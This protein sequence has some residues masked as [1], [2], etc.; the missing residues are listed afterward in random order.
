METAQKEKRTR[1]KRQLIKK[2]VQ[3]TY[4]PID[5][6]DFLRQSARNEGIRPTT[7][8]SIILRNWCD[9]KRLEK[10]EDLVQSQMRKGEKD[11]C[12]TSPG[13]ETAKD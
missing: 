5:D 4:L 11:G 10:A 1:R 2:K 8:A 9:K 3:G 6:Y 12:E 13:N 7:L